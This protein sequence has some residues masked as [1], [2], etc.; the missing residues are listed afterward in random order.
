MK[1]IVIFAGEIESFIWLLKVAGEVHILL[2]YRISIY[3]L[4]IYMH[5]CMYYY[6]YEDV[7]RATYI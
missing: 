5:A 4:V 2:F 1:D 3:T 6:K 7:P